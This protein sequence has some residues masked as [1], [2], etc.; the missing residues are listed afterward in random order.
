M[1]NVRLPDTV[2]PR[3]PQGKGSLS[4]SGPRGVEGGE[5]MPAAE[6]LGARAISLHQVARVVQARAKRSTAS[7]R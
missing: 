2:D 7:G 3:G 4:A 1:A 6:D 5:R